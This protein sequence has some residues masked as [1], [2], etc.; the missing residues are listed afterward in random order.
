MKWGRRGMHIG[1][2][3]E[4]QKEGDNWEYPR[5]RRVD[6]IKMGLRQ[7]KIDWIDLAWDWS[8]WMVVVDMVMNLNVPQIAG[9]FLS[10]HTL[11]FSRTLLHE[12]VL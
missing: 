3:W 1:Y 2:W 10:S 5:G 12:Q 7:D 6:N 8:Q 4:R 9:K 11:G